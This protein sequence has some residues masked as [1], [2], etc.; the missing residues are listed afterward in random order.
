[1]PEETSG[2]QDPVSSQARK[3]I[4]GEQSDLPFDFVTSTL[5]TPSLSRPT[6]LA[7]TTPTSTSPGKFKGNNNNFP[8]FGGPDRNGQKDKDDG[9]LDQTTEHVLIS[10]A[11]IGETLSSQRL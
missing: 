4:N 7:D 5:S 2:A 11:S 9:R 3:G 6:A 1:M 8:K 10:A